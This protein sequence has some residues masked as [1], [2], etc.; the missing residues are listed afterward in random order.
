MRKIHIIIIAQ[1]IVVVK[2]K[3]L[4]IVLYFAHA[5]IFGRKL[6]CTTFSDAHTDATFSSKINTKKTANA[7]FFE[8]IMANCTLSQIYYFLLPLQHF[9]CFTGNSDLQPLPPV[10]PFFRNPRKGIDHDHCR[11]S[12]RHQGVVVQIAHLDIDSYQLVVSVSDMR[13]SA[14]RRPYR[15]ALDKVSS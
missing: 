7:V 11:R 5:T 13:S 4:D 8:K 6:S 10:L 2:L 1:S 15:R 12:L 9:F 3:S 14:D